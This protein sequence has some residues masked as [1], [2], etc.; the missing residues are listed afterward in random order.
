MALLV[1]FCF[2]GPNLWHMK[3]PRLGIELE[4]QLP[5]YAAIVMQDPIHVC[6]LQ[7]SSQ[8]CQILNSLRKATD[9]TWALMDASWVCKLLSHLGTPS[10]DGFLIRY[11]LSGWKKILSTLLR[12]VIMD[13]CW[14]LFRCLFCVYFCD[15][16][17][18]FFLVSKC[19]KLH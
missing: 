8:Q 19:H 12:A 1:C 13:C 11:S 5:G 7:H 4:L 9:W 16:M 2:L 6:N 15:H 3:D 17:I 18:F 14:I 10:Y